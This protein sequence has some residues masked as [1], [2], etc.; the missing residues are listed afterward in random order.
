MNVGGPQ[1][2]ARVSAPQVSHAAEA[3]KTS[4]VELKATADVADVRA[5]ANAATVDGS[6]TRAAGAEDAAKARVLNNADQ[7][8]AAASQAPARGLLHDIKSRGSGKGISAEEGTNSCLIQE[9]DKDINPASL[10]HDIKRRGSGKGI[11]D[12][13]SE[14]APVQDANREILA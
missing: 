1:S 7:P 13:G 10:L 2:Q 5:P 12:D 6:R 14:C 8:S 4:S 11:T 9:A 3:P